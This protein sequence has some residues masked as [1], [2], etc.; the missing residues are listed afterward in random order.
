MGLYSTHPSL[1]VAGHR[2]RVPAELHATWVPESSAG[3][4]L[5]QAASGSEFPRLP[6][7]VAVPAEGTSCLCWARPL[8]W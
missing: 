7:G 3:Q 1:G 2:A 8:E 6:L 5:T 4:L